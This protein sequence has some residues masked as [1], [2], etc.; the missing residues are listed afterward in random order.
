MTAFTPALMIATAGAFVGMGGD[1][2]RDDQTLVDVFLR[3][4][5]LPPGSP[6]S[7]AFIR[8]AGYWAHFSH[9]GRNSSWP[10]KEAATCADLAALGK[11]KAILREEPEGG[12]IA[13][14]W[15]A[16]RKEFV[17]AGLVVGIS[18]RGDRQRGTEC[19]MIEGD[20]TATGKFGGRCVQ[21]LVRRLSGAQ[22]DRFL[23]WVDLDGRNL[24]AKA[25]VD[26]GV[27]MGRVVALRAA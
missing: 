8:H 4:A 24:I 18:R 13:L 3:E 22:G 10:L 15:S 16:A 25:S 1:V 5:G 2:A 23:R 21:T 9:M 7:A 17:H 12:D 26:E 20:V 14:L 27:H 19:L 11:E 6:W